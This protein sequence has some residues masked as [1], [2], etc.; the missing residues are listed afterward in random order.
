MQQCV[1]RSHQR[2]LRKP[3]LRCLSAQDIAQC[4]QGHALVVRHV[5]FH[6]AEGLPMRLTRNGKV[7]GIHEAVLASRI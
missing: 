2:R 6:D 5:V 4:Y 1:V 7:N 3:A